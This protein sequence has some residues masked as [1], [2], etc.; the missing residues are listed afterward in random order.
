MP[1]LPHSPD[2]RI[3]KPERFALVESGDIV[4]LIPWQMAFTRGRDSRPRDAALEASEEAELERASSAC[5]HAGGVK[6][7]A[8]NLLAEP[9]SAGNEQTWNTL[10]AKFPCEDDAA[11][12]AAAAEAVLASATEGED[13]NAPPWP[14]DKY[15]AEVLF[16]VISFRS[17]LSGPG[18]DGQRFAPAMHHPRRHRVG[19]DRKGHASLLAENR[20]R[21]GRVLARVLAAVLTVEPHRIGGKVPAGLRGH[22]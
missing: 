17:A 4:L 13:G 20:R 15:A 6:V 1:A 8:R 12:S 10:M 16:D 7:A 14:D 2:G 5:R 11:E 9:R 22:T 19:G 18:H 3:K 21:A